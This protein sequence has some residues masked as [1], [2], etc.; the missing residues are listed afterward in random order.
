MDERTLRAIEAADTDELL[1]IIDGHSE[2]REWDELHRLRVHCRSAV[3]RGKQLWAIDEHIRYRLAL[4]AP[5]EHAGP[6]VTE[7][8]ARWTLGPLPEV[9]ASTHSWSELEPHLA[10]GP[11]RALVAHER[12]VRGE[13]LRGSDFDRGVVELPGGLEP[14]EP[15]YAVATYRSDRAEFPTPPLPAFDWR[16]LPDA[17][18]AASD[19]EGLDAVL[20]LTATWVEHSSGRAEARA[21]EG[22][23]AAAIAALGLGRAG[24]ALVPPSE[25]LAW[26]AWAAASGGAHGRRAGAAAGRFSAW[27]AL[28]ALTGLEWPAHPDDLGEA[29]DEM[30][31]FLWSDASPE[32]W[33]LRFAVEDPE[34]GLAWAI[35]AVDLPPDG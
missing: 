9:A 12:I 15:T 32:G 8:R 10:P 18:H 30:R 1:R 13:D 25:V 6:A 16:D 29:A 19:T 22:S 4:E 33:I 23:A 31:W 2:V 3:E 11:E 5:A 28:A 34:H 35:S 17:G 7:G 24:L 27:W 20:A 14:W 26:M 21:V